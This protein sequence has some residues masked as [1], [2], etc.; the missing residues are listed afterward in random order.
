MILSDPIQVTLRI[1]QEFEDLG[2]RY[3]IGGSLASSLHGIPRTTNNADI[4]AE[5]TLKHIPLLVN[6]LT[7]EFYI[8]ADLIQEAIQNQGCFNI[9]YLATMFKIDIFVLKSGS[10]SQEEM[11]RRKQYQ[12]SESNDSNLFIASA[13]DVIIN[14]LYWYQLGGKISR[15]QWQD[16]LG[17]IQVQQEQLDLV[18]LTKAAKQ[19][20]VQ[21]L[22]EQALV[23]ARISKKFD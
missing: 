2:I 3:F 14:K 21:K 22:L 13:E 8:D 4:V 11:D 19:Q 16:V 5:I 6:A 17:V 23:E 1:A 12:V 18:Y 9:I 10:A 7:S 20:G 15:R